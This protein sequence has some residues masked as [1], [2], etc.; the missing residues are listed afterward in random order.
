MKFRK[1]RIL[2]FLIAIIF[3]CGKDDAPQNNAPVIKGQTFIVNENIT[4]SAVIGTVTATDSDSDKLQFTIATNDN[5]FFKITSAGE[6]S[7]VSGKNLD[8]ELTASH[9]IKVQVSDGEAISS[10][11]ITIKVTDV[12]ENNVPDVGAQTFDVSEYVNTETVIGIVTATDADDNDLIY[13]IIEDESGLFEIT[14]A[15]ALSLAETKTLNFETAKSHVLTI[16]ITDGT[17]M[18]DVLITINVNDDPEPGEFAKSPRFLCHG[19]E[20]RGGE[21]GD[22]YNRPRSIY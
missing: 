8:F 14:E 11:T 7:L 9:T 12:D 18:V 20:N 1:N 13:S 21:P 4:E 2:Y 19:M 15:G 6:L 17:A 16:G 22:W 10:A 3:S 5:N